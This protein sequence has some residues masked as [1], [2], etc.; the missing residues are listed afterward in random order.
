MDDTLKAALAAANVFDALGVRWFLGGSLASSVHGI[1]R[2]TFDADI[3]ADL[4]AQHVRPFIKQLG[5]EWYADEGAILDAITHRSSFNLIHFAT[6]M[7]VDVFLPKARRFDSGEFT[8]SRKMSVAE[9]S[10]VE[11]SVCC[12][13]DIVVAKL[14]WYRLGGEDSERQWQDVLGVL[15]LNSGR[16]DINLLRQSADEVGVADLLQRALD[17]AEAG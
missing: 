9:G 17:L 11:A 3:M 16:L 14:E 7:K 4:G 2:A 15:R 12:A 10:S 8:R 13:E 6:A 5:N 1:P